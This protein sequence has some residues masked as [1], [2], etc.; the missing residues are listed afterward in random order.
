MRS[1]RATVLQQEGENPVMVSN[2]LRHAKEA[3]TLYI[4]ANAVLAG[5]RVAAATK[6]IFGRS[7]AH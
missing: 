4:Y 1:L 5:K 3:C 6:A 7:S 2:R